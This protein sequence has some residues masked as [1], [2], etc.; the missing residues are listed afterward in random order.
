MSAPDNPI[1]N[2]PFEPPKRHWQIDESGAF[3]Q[4]TV[5]QRRR[6]EHIVP[7]AAT[8]RL[9]RQGLLN[10]EESGEGGEPFRP[11]RWSMK[12]AGMLRLGEAFCQPNGV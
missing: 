3:T 7:V 4:T 2:S 5:E 8:R 11:I 12:F 10:L 6:S 1:L 9:P